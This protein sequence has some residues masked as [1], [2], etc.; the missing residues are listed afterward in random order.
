LAVI[1]D[2]IEELRGLMKERQVSAYLVPS[3]DPHHS[4]YVPE[5]WQRR[6]WIS[7]FT[8]SSGDVV[9]TLD[10]AGLWT[11]SRYFLQAEKELEGIGIELFKMG[12]PDVP[13][14][15]TWIA[16]NLRTGDS[17]GADPQLVPQGRAEETCR[18]LL[19]RGIGVKWLE[20]NLIDILWKNRPA[21]SAAPITLQGVEYSGESL[22]QKLARVREQMK[23]EN[24]RIHIITTL[25]DI[26]WLFNIR[27]QDVAFNPVAVAYAIVTQENAKLFIDPNKIP[28]SVSESLRDS[29][30][31][32][33]YGQFKGELSGH[34]KK[35]DRVWVDP[36]G[37]SRWITGIIEEGCDLL[38]KRSPVTVFKSIKN[39]TEISG[40]RNCHIRDGL[41]MVRFLSWLKRT[42][43]QGG[44]TEISAAE[45]LDA[46]R[47]EQ[48]LYQGPSFVPISSYAAH[49]AIVHYRATPETD[50]EIGPQGLYLIDSGGQYLDGTTDITRTVAL[51]S[52]TEE[53]RDRFTLVLKGHINLALA[54]F[55]R[56][57]KGIQLDTLARLPLW[58]RGL[59][60]GHGTGHG[61]GSYLNVHEGPQTL[62][63]S[64]GVDVAL[65][66]GMFLSIEPGY[67][68]EGEYGI[69]IE[70]LAY[71]VQDE[72][73]TTESLEFY[74]FETVTLCPIDLAL[75]LPER[76]TRQE[77]LYLNRYHERVRETLSPHL[78]GDDRQFLEDATRPL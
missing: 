14:L 52:P 24:V 56:G 1:R 26:A 72:A 75:I 21:L 63:H 64:T 30:Q 4:E 17:L 28:D 76:L 42:A 20:E 15:V 22:E 57:T 48:D 66:K 38:Y 19:R 32:L 16:E 55:P 36:A 69:R 44:V 33:P 23:A 10:R 13:D 62:S 7:G 18:L 27:G 54:S 40:F 60:Y 46:F 50:V 49:G 2:R 70:N 41:A 5:A 51:G 77:L 47:K 78:S 74:R 45:T 25:D 3:A 65:E 6:K 67:Y 11:D 34:A 73:R 39:D 53:Q 37:V 35:K 71:V 43:A 31:I 29:V 61:I 59:N 9:V 58:D 12:C 68:K 8:G